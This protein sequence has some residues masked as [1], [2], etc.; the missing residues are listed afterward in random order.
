MFQVGAP[1]YEYICGSRKLPHP[2][3]FSFLQL[4]LWPVCNWLPVSSCKNKREKKGGFWPGMWRAYW[5]RKTNRVRKRD[6][7]VQRIKT[8][9]AIFV[10]L[11]NLQR[12]LF[13]ESEAYFNTLCT[14]N[15][16][17]VDILLRVCFFVIINVFQNCNIVWWN[18]SLLVVI[19]SCSLG[20]AGRFWN[21]ERVDNNRKDVNN[22]CVYSVCVNSVGHCSNCAV[23]VF[24]C[25]VSCRHM[26]LKY[27]LF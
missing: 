23:P 27:L 22:C 14:Q 19:D 8:E 21:Q 26:F 17:R 24:T 3:F 9:I 15:V 25:S 6:S 16:E 11:G 5:G 18:F 2:T 4:L 12:W 1:F 20:D 10:L 7:G 13:F